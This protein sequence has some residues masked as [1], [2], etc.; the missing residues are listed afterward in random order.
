MNT[1]ET[2]KE[3]PV[4]IWMVED[5]SRYRKSLA[6]VINSTKGMLCSEIFSTCEDAFESLEVEKYP[7]VILLDI[8]LPGMSGITGIQKFKSFSPKSIL[9]Y[10]PSMK[11]TILFLMLFA[12]ALQAIF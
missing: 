6:A 2:S 10:L 7:D 1:K 11:I 8:G 5:N 9:L 4:N 12:K 3:S